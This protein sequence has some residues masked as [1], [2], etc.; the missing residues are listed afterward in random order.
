MMRFVSLK[1][2]AADLGTQH[3]CRRPAHTR[4]GLVLAAA[5]LVAPSSPALAQGAGSSSWGVVGTFVPKWNVPSSLEPVAAL[6]FSEDE[7]SIAQQELEG[8][9]FRIG[10]AR[11]RSLGGDW[12]VSFLRRTFDSHSA[13]GVVGSQCVNDRCEDVV[14]ESTRH[15]VRLNGV[16]IHKFIPFV[17]IARRAQ[18]GVN[19]GGGVGSVSGTVD[20]QQ[21]TVSYRC[22]YPTGGPQF[23]D[24]FDPTVPFGSCQGFG[25]TVS[26]VQ[27]TTADSSTSDF[28]RFLKNGSSVLPIGHVELS[29]AVAVAPRLKIRVAGGLN[30]PG[31]NT[32]AFSAVYFFSAQ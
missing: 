27:T 24:G 10:I 29:A 25:G 13:S 31:T 21:S 1:T 3:A 4:I 17:T 20:S 5:C 2:R 23:N 32:I 30:Y 18:V 22:T 15:D 11:G 26:D 12:G 16:E 28:S 6:H 7:L 8:N 19:V 14:V 9:E